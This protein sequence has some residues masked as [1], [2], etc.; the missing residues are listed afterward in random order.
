MSKSS[1]R[2]DKWGELLA[3]LSDDVREFE[4]EKQDKLLATKQKY[5]QF[6]KILELEALSFM[7]EKL[8][9]KLS[10]SL[11][12]NLHNVITLFSFTCDLAKKDDYQDFI[13]EVFKTKAF[14]LR[15]FKILWRMFFK[16]V[17]VA[18][19]WFTIA[20]LTGFCLVIYK[21]I[22][23]SLSL[24]WGLFREWMAWTVIIV[25]ALFAVLLFIEWILELTCSPSKESYISIVEKDLKRD[26]TKE[27][28]I[29]DRRQIKLPELRLLFLE[30]E[31]FELQP[32]LVIKKENNLRVRFELQIKTSSKFSKLL[33]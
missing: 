4:R 24:S 11:K 23:N 21:L 30:L 5:R 8:Q 22:K 19:M 16:F 10:L 28:L 1:D 13:L 27:I 2:V 3:E 32:T 31:K 14:F 17:T 6:Y 12:Q 26:F 25:L 20:P 29:S 18:D 7:P 15:P 9:Q 33:Q